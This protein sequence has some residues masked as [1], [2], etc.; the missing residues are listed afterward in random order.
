M[1]GTPLPLLQVKLRGSHAWRGQSHH[2]CRAEPECPQGPAVPGQ[3]RDE[4]ASP[5]RTRGPEVP[6]SPMRSSLALDGSGYADWASAFIWGLLNFSRMGSRSLF[7]A[8]S[9]EL[10]RS[11]GWTTCPKREGE[12]QTVLLPQS[13]GTSAPPHLWSSVQFPTVAVAQ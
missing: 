6:A 12:C 11:P 1:Q 4:G 9:T 10:F 5:S 2:G 13:Q 7:K 8:T 3:K